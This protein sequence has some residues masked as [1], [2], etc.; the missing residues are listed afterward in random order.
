MNSSALSVMV[1]AHKS[2][3]ARHAEIKLCG[4]QKRMTSLLVTTRLINVFGHYPTVEEA[5]ASFV[6]SIA[7][8]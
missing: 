7:D 4:L 2:Y 3:L 5:A 6:G 8:P 1:D